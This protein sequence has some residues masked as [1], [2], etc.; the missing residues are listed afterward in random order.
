M[1]GF[2]GITSSGVGVCS[3]CEHAPAAYVASF[4]ACRDL[5]C[6]IWP[7]FDPLDIDEGCRLGVTESVLGAVIPTGT[8]VYAESDAPTQ[9]SLSAK[10]EAHA[11]SSLLQDPALTRARRCHLAAIR[12]PAR[13]SRLLRL[14]RTHISPRLCF[15]LLCG[16][17]FACQSGTVTLPV[18]SAARSLTGGVTTPFAVLAEETGFFV[19]TRSATLFALLCLNLPPFH[20]SSKNL[21]SCSI[22]SPLTLEAPVLAPPRPA[23]ALLCRSPPRSRL[24]PPWCLGPS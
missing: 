18:D 16:A 8:S 22:P 14:P 20:L 15:G 3:V 12:A 24:G 21:A 17:S 7:S 11:V 10:I 13:G 2:L 1:L 5:C 6:V 23:P 9:K 4:A 19:I